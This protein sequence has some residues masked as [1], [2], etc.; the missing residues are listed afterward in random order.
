MLGLKFIGAVCVLAGCG[1][2]G[3]E[4]G[5]I[6]RRR[7]WILREM[8]Q[9]FTLFKSFTETYRLPLIL[10]FGRVALQVQPPVSDFYKALA[11][12]FE[13]QIQ[14]DGICLGRE[15]VRTMGNTFDREDQELFLRLGDFIGIQD[16]HAQ[17]D[18]VADCIDEMRERIGRLESERP[19][20]EKLYFVLSMTICGFLVILF[21]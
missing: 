8:I 1:Y 10:V 15:T 13:G 4:K 11:D 5:A 17:A 21:I 18:A 6:L 2:M 3:W 12:A 19:G 7:I 9:S 20:R 16:V 14:P